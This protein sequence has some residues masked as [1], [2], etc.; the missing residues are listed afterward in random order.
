MP[1]GVG[2]IVML[3][4]VFAR[5]MQTIPLTDW[6]TGGGVRDTNRINCTGEEGRSS[7]TDRTIEELSIKNAQG[8]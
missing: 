1:Y 7:Q 2:G 5:I 3:P 6:L 4:G 8:R